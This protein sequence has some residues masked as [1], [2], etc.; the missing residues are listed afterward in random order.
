MDLSQDHTSFPPSP[1]LEERIYYDLLGRIQSGAY[2]QG[3]RLPTENDFASEFDVSRPVV[4]AAL[5][6][7][8][9]AGLIVSRRGAGSFV[10]GAGVDHANAFRALGSI[11]DIMQ[12]YNFRR[13][14]ESEAAAAA[15]MKCTK[16]HLVQLNDLQAKIGEDLESGQ[17]TID[18]DIEFH[19]LLARIAENRFI[20]QSLVMLQPQMRFVSKFMRSLTPESYLP[21][22]QR[23][24]RQHQ[25]IIDALRD[26]DAKTA[27]RA[28]RRH[29][30]SSES[31]VFKGTGDA[32]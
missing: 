27:R 22:K 23:M 20:V 28:M 10:E 13:L 17:T 16:A 8:R 19:A 29:I 11:E 32:D 5:A 14:I 3:T 4:R 26:R 15:A 24:L 21:L 12:Y 9:E 31:Q 30:D 25:D 7:L 2:P 6:R 18:N 1:R